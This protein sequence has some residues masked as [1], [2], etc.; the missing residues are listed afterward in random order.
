MPDPIRPPAPA[1]VHRL[2]KRASARLV[3]DIDSQLA[4]KL[5]QAIEVVAASR[6]AVEMGVVIDRAR[7]ARIAL[8][9]GLERMLSDGFELAS[10]TARAGVKA[11]GAAVPHPNPPSAGD[12]TLPVPQG[13]QSQ[14][15]EKVPAYQADVHAH[16]EA[17][18]WD[19]YLT[20]VGDK[21]WVYAYWSDR[22]EMQDGVTPYPGAQVVMLGASGCCHIIAG[23]YGKDA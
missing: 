13:W 2:P 16:Y 5:D 4:G 1:Q 19:R 18:G 20:F 12:G 21:D 14:E 7:V 22:L 6:V 11:D 9:R 10:A 15:R 3:L 8:M 17:A 23:L